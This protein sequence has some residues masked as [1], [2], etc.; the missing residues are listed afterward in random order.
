[1][2]L[3]NNISSVLSK[4]NNVNLAVG[5]IYDYMQIWKEWYAGDVANF[6]HYTAR[7][8]NGTTTSLER[9]TM[10][11]AKKSCEDMAKLLWTEKTQIKLKKKENTKKLW[12]VLDNKVNNFTTNFPVFIEQAFALGNGALI[13]YKDNG[14]TI[15]DYVTGDL[16][17]PYKFTNSYIY[18]L[19]TIS[20]YSETEREEGKKK[21]KTIYYTHL[22]YHEYEDG[23]YIRK[24][25]LYKSTNEKELGKDIDFK[26][27]YP[28]IKEY[29]EIETDTPYF[30][31][32]KP[33]LANNLD[34][35]SPSGIS[36]FANSIDRFKSIDLKYDSFMQE[37]KLGKKRILV[38]N[39]TLKAKAV[40]NENGQVNYVQ[41]FDTE[42][43]VYVAVEGMEKQPAKE[44]DFNLRTQD[45]V[46]AINADLNWLSSNVGLGSNF[47]KFDGVSTKTATEV[48]SEN[49]EAFRTR[50]H[51]LINV[52]DVVYD[53]VRAICHIEGIDAS[54]VTIIPDDSII[55]DKNAEKTLALMEVQ[56]GLKSKKSYLM[57][58]EGLTEKQAE[59]ELKAINDEKMTN[60]EVFGF[61]TEE[62]PK[63]SKKEEEKDKK[64]EKKEDK[65]EE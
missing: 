55:E 49:S 44:I 5:D 38:D 57:K 6:H 41:Y 37:F 40:P 42:D 2:E 31:I 32:L 61:P 16:F 63:P 65:K 35:A 39:S 45:H 8:A 60:Q 34:M 50:T 19:V 11:M 9:L 25:E 7:L 52:N 56:Q 64:E 10:N 28:D 30:Q 17:I 20:R 1:M 21:E 18:G 23:K 33:N 14:Q 3:Y 12:A 13:E 46:D 29:D 27:H 54:D 36:I 48:I 22:T 24:H 58:Y 51:H 62:N 53:L 4:K 47:Y 43:Q 26:E 15:I 59:D